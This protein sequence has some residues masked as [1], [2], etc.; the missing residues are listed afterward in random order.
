[1]DETA[2]IAA[3]TNAMIATGTDSDHGIQ[4][5]MH[6]EASPR[7]LGLDEGTQISQ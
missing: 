4:Y 6:P 1:M 3:T 5:L 7:T 2:T